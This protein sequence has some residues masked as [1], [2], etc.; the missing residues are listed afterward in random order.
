M[1][2]SCCNLSCSTARFRSLRLSIVLA[3][4]EHDS[5]QQDGV[6]GLLQWLAS[7]DNADEET[8]FVANVLPYLNAMP[9]DVYAAMERGEFTVSFQR[10]APTH[11]DSRRFS[12]EA[13]RAV[14]HALEARLLPPEWEVGG[15]R[16]IFTVKPKQRRGGGK[17]TELRVLQKATGEVQPARCDPTATPRRV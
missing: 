6:S 8:R 14:L 16:T 17:V 2:P 10:E 3:I 13:Y 12:N 5:V 15:P 11:A 9:A 1:L 7:E 4:S